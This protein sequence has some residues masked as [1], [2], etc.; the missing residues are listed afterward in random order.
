MKYFVFP[1]LIV[2]LTTTPCLRVVIERIVFVAVML[3]YHLL[4]EF[5]FATLYWTENV[6]TAL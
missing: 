5:Q 1:E 3:L 2:I 6:I 4:V